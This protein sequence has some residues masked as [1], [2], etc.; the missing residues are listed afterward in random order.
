L[1]GRSGRERWIVG[2]AVARGDGHAALLRRTTSGIRLERTA[3]VTWSGEDDA[4]DLRTLL[5]EAAP[6]IRPNRIRLAILPA[7]GPFT[8]EVKS[9]PVMHSDD[10]DK[11]AE[12]YQKGNRR[13]RIE[14]PCFGR[15]LQGT[16]EAGPAPHEQEGILLETEDS[17]VQGLLDLGQG[18]GVSGTVVVPQPFALSALTSSY[19]PGTDPVLL[20][21]DGE[22][23]T[24]LTAVAGR[25]LLLHRA[26][27]LTP[28][29]W[30][31]SSGEEVGG[32]TGA[33][34]A[35]GLLSET[36]TAV[37]KTKLQTELERT[38]HYLKTRFDVSP[39]TVVLPT[40]QAELERIIPQSTK[41]PVQILTESAEPR[42]EWDRAG[43][44]AYGAALCAAN[45]EN[46]GIL[47]L[48]KRKKRELSFSPR[49][50]RLPLRKAVG[51]ALPVLLLAFAVIQGG[52]YL[53]AKRNGEM[54]T[55]LET[56]GRQ[57]VDPDLERRLARWERQALVLNHI[58]SAQY[59]WSELFRGL[60]TSLPEGVVVDEVEGYVPKNEGIELEDL[61]PDYLADERKLWGFSVDESE[62]DEAPALFTIRGRAPGLPEVRRII[63]RLEASP[64]FGKVT[65][66]TAAL[67]G[68]SRA[69][70]AGPIHFELLCE[71]LV[72]RGR[73]GD[74]NDISS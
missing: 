32:G 34:Y 20:L 45:R 50:P 43:F 49:L 22:S 53:V 57:T 41:L 58:R 39:T 36:A 62:E 17:L 23:E 24:S 59:L 29:P 35:V 68:G 3:K 6:G 12:W 33:D 27:D 16:D 8:I 15:W 47:P 64:A 52:K 28:D 2:V 10:F 67:E 66:S 46:V 11:A 7:G 70:G 69:P 37:S 1:I 38:A 30:E 26:V 51:I 73:E 74:V 55:R 48:P 71:P 63:E 44:L 60:A 18:A 25:R 42:R 13:T 56:L 21:S 4:A 40:P 65:L 54:E 72:E 5:R 14:E 61:D 31:D 19:M 9:F